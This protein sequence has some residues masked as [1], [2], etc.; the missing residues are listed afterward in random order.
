MESSK[1]YCDS[2]NQH[3]FS[4]VSSTPLGG[5]HKTRFLGMP[6]WSRGQASMPLLPGDTGSIPG[7]GTE[8]PHA[9]WHTQIATTTNQDSYPQETHVL[10]IRHS[11]PQETHV[12][13]IRQRTF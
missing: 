2:L 13:T 11:Y 1:P 7:Q 5:W 8:I 4:E 10:T 6:W 12:L 3:I 9:M